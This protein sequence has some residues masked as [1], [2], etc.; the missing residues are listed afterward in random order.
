MLCPELLYLQ[1]HHDSN[2]SSDHLSPVSARATSQAST[3]LWRTASRSL[4]SGASSSRSKEAATSRC[5]T[6][7]E[8]Y[9]WLAATTTSRKDKRRRTGSGNQGYH[10]SILQLP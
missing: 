2:V 10:L 8:R 7:Y 4:S 3:K 5:A 1:N 6:S 9:T